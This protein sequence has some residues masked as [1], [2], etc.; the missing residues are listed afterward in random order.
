MAC[1]DMAPPPS[2]CSIGTVR[3]RS[4][5]AA[6]ARRYPLTALTRMRR[7]CRHIVV[8]WIRCR[9]MARRRTRAR[10]GNF[11]P[12]CR[13]YVLVPPTCRG[14]GRYGAREGPSFI[15]VYTARDSKNIEIMNL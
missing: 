7:Q 12:F 3:Q 5:D 11:L 13:R 1:N 2:V 15:D 8:T 14:V 4:L 10:V 6:G 9:R